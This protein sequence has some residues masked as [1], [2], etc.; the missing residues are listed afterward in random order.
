MVSDFIDEHYGFLRLTTEE[1]ELAK[2][3]LPG[4]PKAARIILKFGAQG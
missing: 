1:H 2:M 4:L 3:L